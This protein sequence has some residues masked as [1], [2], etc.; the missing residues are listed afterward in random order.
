MTENSLSFESAS[1]SLPKSKRQRREVPIES[2]CK[3]IKPNGDQCSFCSL[4]DS[5]YCKRHAPK[6]TLISIGTDTWN[7]NMIDSSTNTEGTI[8]DITTANQ[9][10]L[11]FI[12]DK[13]EHEKAMSELIEL[14]NI[15]RDELEELQ[16]I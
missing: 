5:L 7:K 2:L 16:S 13:V 10:I 4:K 6:T 8:L 11:E 15:L 12:N 14:Y 1:I 9:I 3:G